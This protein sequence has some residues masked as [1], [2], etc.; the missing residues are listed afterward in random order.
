MPEWGH[1]PDGFGCVS[2]CCQDPWPGVWRM[3]LVFA[4]AAVAFLCTNGFWR[5]GALGSFIAA[6]VFGVCQVSRLRPRGRGGDTKGS[7]R[8]LRWQ[9]RALPRCKLAD[10]R[11][12]FN[13]P[14]AAL[15]AAPPAHHARLVAPG[16]RQQR[17]LVEGGR[18]P[19]DGLLRRRQHDLVAQPARHR[20]PHL[21]QRV[22]VRHT[23]PI[24][25]HSLPSRPPAVRGPP[26]L[27]A[28][29]A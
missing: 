22:H 13:A 20:P 19:G 10:A 26:G 16:L 25:R 21:H 28:L 6:I 11:R 3:T 8:I 29:R 2:C 5:V 1:H 18:P 23:D 17:D 15:G 4:T 12:F 7:A 9:R 27:P 14:P 24:M